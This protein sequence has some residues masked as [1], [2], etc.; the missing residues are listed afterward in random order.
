MMAVEMELCWPTLRQVGFVDLVRLAATNGFSALAV[1]CDLCRRSGLGLTALRRTL[2]DAGIRVTYLDGLPGALPRTP[3][4]ARWTQQEVFDLASALG[5]ERLNVAHFGGD[6][7]TPIPVLGEALA[8]AAERAAA[9]ELKVMVEFIPGTGVPDLQSAV[10]LV[11]AAEVPD[12]GILLDSWHLYRSGGSPSLLTGE[13]LRLVAGLQLADRRRSQDAEP[14]VPM[15]GRLLPGE[16]E[17]PLAAM[18]AAVLAVHP[19][20][21]V[22]IEIFS[23]ELLTMDPGEAAIRAAASL[24][25]T[26]DLVANRTVS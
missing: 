13:G 1:S 12:L 5:A 26:L 4:I 23:E 8:R 14:Y 10:H 21:P 15:T 7:A 17:L 22:G 19:E 25:R 3:E 16:G 6:P 2:D 20:L 11:K 24:R 18:V 9:Q